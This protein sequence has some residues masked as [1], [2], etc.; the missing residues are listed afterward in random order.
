VEAAAAE[1]FDLIFMDA[2]M[3]EMDGFEA[4]RRIRESE[5]ATGRHTPIVAMTAH[6]MAGDRERCL[7]S[8]MDDYLSKPLQKA[9]LLAIFSR[10]KLLGQVSAALEALTGPVVLRRPKS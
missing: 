5:Q 6:A 2:Q 10:E 7:A 9:A 3:P 1:D 8:G 4:T